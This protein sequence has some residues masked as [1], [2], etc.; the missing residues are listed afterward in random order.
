MALNLANDE[1]EPLPEY[2]NIVI[3]A[4]SDDDGFHICSLILNMFDLYWP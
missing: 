3:A 1:S 2:H 4:D